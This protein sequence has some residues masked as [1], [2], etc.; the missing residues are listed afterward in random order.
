M[1]AKWRHRHRAPSNLWASPVAPGSCVPWTKSA[2]W[3]LLQYILP[4]SFQHIPTTHTFITD[5]FQQVFLIRWIT[6][7]NGHVWKRTGRPC[8]EF[9]DRT[10]SNGLSLLFLQRLD[11]INV[12]FQVKDNVNAPVSGPLHQLPF[13]DSAASAR[14]ATAAYLGVAFPNLTVLSLLP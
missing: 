9:R 2:G 11:T 4:G 12:I 6:K 7:K 14:S 10:Q 5:L 1:G 13:S 8:A 3:N